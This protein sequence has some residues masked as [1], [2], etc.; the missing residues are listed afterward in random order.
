MS[1]LGSF[2]VPFTLF[3]T[4]RLLHAGGLP[5]DTPPVPRGD[6]S[7]TLGEARRNALA[8]SPALQAIEAQLRA[9]DGA[10]RQ[11]RAFANPD[12]LLEAEDFGG[13]D[14]LPVTPQ[15]TFSLSQSIEWFGKRS[16]RIA[17]SERGRDVVARDL[18]KGRRDL[19]AEVDRAFAALL[20]AQERLAIAEQNA[21]TAR[22]VTRAVASLV[23]A[24]EASPV[25]AARAESDEALTSIDLGNARRDLELTRRS[26][27]S[28][29]GDVAP[30]FSA[31]AGSLATIA[32]LPDRDLALAGLAELP[33]LTRWDA[34]IARQA[35]LVTY[36]RRQAIPD[37]T[38]SVGTRSLSGSAGRTWVAGL[39]LPI[40]LFTQLAGARAEAGARQ[41]QAGFERDAEE[42]RVRTELLAAHTTLSRALDEVR[43]IRDEVLPKAEKVY[44]AL[45][46][47]YRRGKFRL[48]DL[49][50]ARRTLAQTRLRYVDALVRLNLADADLQ[51]L[52]PNAADDTHGVDR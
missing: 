4:V 30:T 45:N 34:E 36:A 28:L 44:D 11:A 39:A 14:S 7:L 9:A 31:A 12:L 35:S 17:A 27:A 23:E 16:A 40:P 46:E 21:E 24:G 52:I 48:L 22:E 32:P 13:D 43:A 18:E 29:W 42:V 51:R 6:G 47:G 15:R 50:E 37:L 1:R 20:G 19:L 5:A 10:S 8:S 41:Q 25:E 3:L 33:D 38:L 26:L 49:L 2:L